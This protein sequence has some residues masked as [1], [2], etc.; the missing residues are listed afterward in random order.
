MRER[1][2]AR[3]GALGARLGR[4]CA[5]AG[6]ELR[7][8]T[9]GLLEQDL[10][11]AERALSADAELDR[12][13]AECE[14]AAQSLLALQAP[15]ARDLRTVLAAVYCAD[16]IERMGDL[17]R[18][19]A[20]LA[21]REHPAPVVPA[22]LVPACVELGELTGAMAEDLRQLLAGT[23]GTAFARLNA[24]DDRVDRLH[25]ELLGAVTDPGWTH[26]VRPAVNVALAARFYE[27][28]ADQAVS[29][30]KRWD[31]VRTGV[32]PAVSASGAAGSRRADHR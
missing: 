5:M 25:E 23:P 9:A 28:F 32:L 29:V 16:R 8:A 11:A 2:H 3:L 20:E 24:A 30:G 7:Q 19:L 15:V 1:F 18:H 4:M 6:Q 10:A 22:E 27:R 31:F 21:R 26:G 17:A 14:R 12:A 13:R